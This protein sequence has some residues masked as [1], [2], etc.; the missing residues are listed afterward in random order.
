MNSSTLLESEARRDILKMG[1]AGSLLAAATG[2]AFAAVSPVAPGADMRGANKALILSYIQS[3]DHGDMAKVDAIVAPNAQWW[4]LGRREFDRKTAMGINRGRYPP[5]VARTSTI[6]GMTA[7]G[8]RVAVE[9]ETATEANGATMYSVFHHLFV[10]R[11]GVID[12]AQE[13]LDPP[14]LAKPFAV[15]QA[16]PP[17][18]SV[19][20]PDPPGAAAEAQT[21]TIAAAFLGNNGPQMLAHELR[22]P[23]FRWWLTGFGYRDLDSYISKMTSTMQARPKIAPVSAD[24]KIMGMTVEGGRVGVEVSRNITFPDYDYVN[25]FHIVLIVRDGKILEMREHNDLAAA[26]RGGLPV[27]ESLS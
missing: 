11:N 13:F 21:R 10:V 18:L 7:E 25:R 19:S 14:P 12:S 26:I 4:I 2:S 5:G 3:C 24:T 1:L 17:G 20:I 15:S 9:Y 22:A 27:L 23:G 8:D 16:H 6:L